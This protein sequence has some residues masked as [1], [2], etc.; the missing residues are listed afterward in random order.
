VVQKRQG[1]E[2]AYEFDGEPWQNVLVDLGLPGSSRVRDL[3]VT[4][5]RDIVEADAD[6]PVQLLRNNGNGNHW[7]QLDLQGVI[8]NNHGIGALVTVSAGGRVQQRVLDNGT[9]RFAQSHRLMHFGLGAATVAQ[10]IQVVWPSGLVQTLDD[11]PADQR[12]VLREPVDAGA[13][14]AVLRLQGTAA[15]AGTLVLDV[16]GIELTVAFAAGAAAAD[17]LAAAAQT[18]NDALPGRASVTSG[19]LVIRASAVAS[20]TTADPGLSAITL[21]PGVNAP[22]TPLGSPV[23]LLLLAALLVLLGTAASRR[24]AAR[25]TPPT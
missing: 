4:N 21:Q 11:V 23:T 12:L 3:L 5:G 24:S 8:S 1:F 6:A 19:V 22:Q 14:D 10:S 7:L 25:A 2:A 9:L 15:A 20:F 18:V 17:I 16:N 13:N